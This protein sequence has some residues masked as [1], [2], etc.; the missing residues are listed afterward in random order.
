M[1]SFFK[2]LALCCSIVS[3]ELFSSLATAWSATITQDGKFQISG[4]SQQEVS[5]FSGVGESILINTD[6]GLV[7][8]GEIT[9]SLDTTK[10]N[11][12]IYNFDSGYITLDVNLLLDAPILSV[13][14]EDPVSF[15]LIESAFLP[16]LNIVE[17]TS[18]VPEPIEFDYVAEGRIRQPSSDP[19]D[20]MVI[21]DGSLA[22][23]QEEVLFIEIVEPLPE[24]ILFIGGGLIETGVFAGFDYF[25][26]NRG[27]IRPRVDP[28]R[29]FIGIEA[30]VKIGANTQPLPP[31]EDP[32]PTPP[33]F[34][35]FPENPELIAVARVPEPSNFLGISLLVGL[36]TLSLKKKL[37]K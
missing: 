29:N 17:N 2:S 14:E 36:G 10:E 35:P 34:D 12:L 6:L 23:A 31:V 27:F 8:S 18:F 3:L 30:G 16:A 32:E 15:N 13:I 5:S 37:L 25:N 4:F 1:S 9:F 26:A 7:P 21:G 20:V 33:E 24:G 11:R 22:P 28:E 19:Q